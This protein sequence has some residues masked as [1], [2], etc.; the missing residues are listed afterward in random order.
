MST[1]VISDV[2]SHVINCMAVPLQKSHL[3][4]LYV[5]V[6]LAIVGRSINYHEAMIDPYIRELIVS[7]PLKYVL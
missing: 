1:S 2:F 5:I 4:Y 6:T 7:I 3:A